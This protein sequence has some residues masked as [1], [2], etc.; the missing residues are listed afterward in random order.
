MAKPTTHVLLIIDM[1]GSM[2]A[3]A[4]DVRGGINS[5]VQNLRDDTARKYR[6]TAVVF[7]TAV[8]TLCQAAKLSEVP[9]LTEANYT[10]RGLT[11]L[12]DAVGATICDLQRSV[13]LGDDDRVLVVVQTD[14]RENASHEWSAGQVAAL[15][16][17]AQGTGKWD[18]VYM[19]ADHDA[20]QQ[21]DSIGIQR[22]HTVSTSRTGM[23]SKA[24]YDSL[25]ATTRG[26]ARGATSGADIAA[27]ASAAGGVVDAASG[28]TPTDSGYAAADT[29]G[30]CDAAG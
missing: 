15:I 29:G 25:G 11:A 26:Y 24:M 14:G 9:E 8:E 3:N 21:A 4:D 12:L 7:D 19:G 6:L 20:W 17:K 1:S 27:A 30:G 10:P 23:T 28:C 18:F 22:S 2:W 16:G 5:Y 13:S